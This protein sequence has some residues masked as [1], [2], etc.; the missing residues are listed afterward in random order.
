MPK[1]NAKNP[2][3]ASTSGEAQRKRIIKM[4]R[5]SDKT[6]YDLRRAGCYQAP[7]RIIELRRMGYVIETTR[8]TLTDRDGYQHRNCALYHLV[9]EPAAAV[10]PATKKPLRPFAK[11]VHHA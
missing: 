9:E 7:A 5:V 8:V 6:S 4:L 3:S 2:I 11:G 1:K 10:L